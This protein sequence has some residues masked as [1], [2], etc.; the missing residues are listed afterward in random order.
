MKLRELIFAVTGVR[1]SQAREAITLAWRER[2]QLQPG[3]RHGYP[4]PEAVKA[5]RRTTL[6]WVL[7]TTAQDEP[8]LF[9]LGLLAVLTLPVLAL[10]SLVGRAM[11]AG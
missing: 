10:L 11:S 7:L 1:N 8:G 4:T 2:A 6:A 9:V 3:S 5:T